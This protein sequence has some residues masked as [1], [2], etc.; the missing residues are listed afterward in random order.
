[1]PTAIVTALVTHQAAAHHQ[2]AIIGML[3][4]ALDLDGHNAM[5]PSRPVT[6]SGP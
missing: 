5:L 2:P 6:N 1:L 4:S 3:P